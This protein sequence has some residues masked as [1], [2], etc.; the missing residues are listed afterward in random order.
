MDQHDYY[1]YADTVI[2]IIK[3]HSFL[4]LCPFVRL[5]Q[6]HFTFPPRISDILV[7]IIPPQ[8]MRFVLIILPILEHPPTAKK[9]NKKQTR[10]QLA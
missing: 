7:R 3:N 9:Q 5:I 2:L 10:I 1:F 8:D 4:F 6:E